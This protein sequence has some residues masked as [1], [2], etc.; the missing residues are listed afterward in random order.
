MPCF[1]DA[2]GN[3]YQDVTKHS[4]NDSTLPFPSTGLTTVLTTTAV[5]KNVA[6]AA[7]F[8]VNTAKTNAGGPI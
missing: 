2:G 3:H 7:A 6:K 4:P 5:A 1:I 8:V